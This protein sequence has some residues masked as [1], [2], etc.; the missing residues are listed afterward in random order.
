M[1][2]GAVPL[3]LGAYILTGGFTQHRLVY[4]IIFMVV[5]FSAMIRGGCYRPWLAGVG[6]DETGRT[7]TSDLMAGRHPTVA[8]AGATVVDGLGVEP[9]ASRAG[10]AGRGVGG[11]R[12]GRLDRGV[13]DRL[14]GARSG[15]AVAAG[16]GAWALL[17]VEG[18]WGRG[19]DARRHRIA[20]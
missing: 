6:A 19:A 16:T 3:L 14:T 13:F 10:V 12:R 4:E 2:R 8:E 17:G 20:R 7:S 18:Q 1:P 15:R 11:T 5:A 9:S